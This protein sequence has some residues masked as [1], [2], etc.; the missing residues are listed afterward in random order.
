MFTLADIEA[1]LPIVRT[2]IPATPQYAWPLLKAATG[3]EVVVKHENHTPIGAFKARGGLVYLHRLKQ[4]RPDLLGDARK[5]W[6]VAR[7]RR[8]APE[9]AGDDRGA[10]RQ[11]DREER[12]DARLR[13]GTH[14]A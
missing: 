3:V 8:P 9:R 10:V 5:P 13:G 4:T 11:L 1:T 2:G 12:R 14:R 6:P 7:V